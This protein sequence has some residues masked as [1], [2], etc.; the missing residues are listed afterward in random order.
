MGTLSEGTAREL[1]NVTDQK[2]GPVLNQLS[3]YRELRLQCFVSSLV[4]VE[5]LPVHQLAHIL[6]L[7][8]IGIAARRAQHR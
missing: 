1:A 3:L 7:L 8:I 5:N 4:L 6:T 2:M